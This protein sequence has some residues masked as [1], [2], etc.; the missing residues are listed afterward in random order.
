M[1][2]INDNI[3]VVIGRQFFRKSLRIERLHG[4][5]HMIQRFRFVS[6]DIEFAEID[7][8]Q[9]TREGI[10]ALLEDFFPMSNK[11]QMVGLTGILFTEA[12]VIQCATTVYQCRWL[13]P[14]V[15]PDA[16]HLPLS[17]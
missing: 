7:V 4:N 13:Q 3:V 17:Q 12:T 8:F 9:Y 5:E 14:Q 16:V 11:Q 6:A 2:F 15:F 1:R 10:S